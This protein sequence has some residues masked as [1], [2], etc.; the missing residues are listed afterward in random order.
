MSV[1]VSHPTGSPFVRAVLRGLA[2]Q[3]LLGGFHTTLALPYRSWM[4]RLVGESLDRRLGQRRF[5]EVPLGRT[6]LHPLPELMRLLARQLKLTPLIHHETGWASVDAV[7]RALD[8]DVAAS[9]RRSD[10]SVVRAVYAY[11]DGALDTFRQAQALGIS[12]LYDLPIAHWRTLRRLL[13]EEAERLPEWAPTME[14]LRDSA[15]KHDRKDE[16]IRLADHIFVASSF[17]RASLTDHFGES[18]TISTVPYGCPP[19]LV[20]QPAQR[21]AGEPLKLLYAGHLAQRKGIAD[22]IA[23][24]NRLEIDW[25]LTMAGPLPAVA[26]EALRQFLSDPRCTWLGVVPHRTLLETM[27][28]SHVFVFPSIVEGFGMVI[29]EAMAA[30]IPVITTPHTAGPDILT[31]G[32]DGFIVPIRDPD[33]IAQ[34]ITLL[35]EDESFRT[36]MAQNA[37]QTAARSGWS[38]YETGIADRVRELIAA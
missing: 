36:Q 34:R 32:H 29:T 20:T 4:S 17:T 27:T 12:R 21:H 2:G 10:R 26:P 11:E 35:A 38:A 19:P 9:L 25:R 33:A 6:H 13:Q 22:L 23:A 16:E 31:E 8:R 24:L 14:G 3:S 5:P 18:L 37:L 28:R 15:A 1:V 30:G 7:Y